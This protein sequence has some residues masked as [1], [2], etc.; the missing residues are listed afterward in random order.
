MQDDDTNTKRVCYACVGDRILAGKIE[1]EGSR[2][3][4]SYCG[5][6]HETLTLDRL[7]DRI[8]EVLQKHFVDTPSGP[9]DFE[10]VLIREGLWEWEREGDPVVCVIADM[11]GLSEETAEDMTALLSDRYAYR[12]AKEG[13][14]NPYGFEAWYEE[15]KPNDRGFRDIW[16]EFRRRI[17]SRARF[18][19]T[20][21]E[22]ALGKVFGGLTAHKAYDGKPVIWE[23]G[24]ED[25]NRFVWRAR[26][27]QSTAELEDVLKSPTR[28]IGPPPSRRATGGRM[29]APGIPVFYGAMDECTCIAEIRPPVGSYVVVARFELLRPVRLLD[30][31]VLGKI[32]VEGSH[33][34]PDYAV[35]RDH[36]VFL[37]RLVSEI[38]RPVM[39]RN[40]AF[41]YL[42][43]QAVAEYLANKAGLDGIVFRSSQTG[44]EGRNVVLFNH[45]CGVE[46]YELPQGTRRLPTLLMT[47][48]RR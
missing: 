29:N 15:R 9:S 2:G 3:L 46:P 23:I 31:D 40:E 36:V 17:R 33:F 32:Y 27:A 5:K 13:W 47:H 20:Y 35:R 25:E 14:E 12:A 11:A 44:G 48:R 45:A 41:D 30:C 4:C 18:F 39:P 21:A 19:S 24:T 42:T 28:E 26:N 16:T 34:D 38:G 43:T 10:Y 6:S 7:A 37:R 8:D 1:E 22:E